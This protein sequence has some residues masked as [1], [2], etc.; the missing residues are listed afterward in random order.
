MLAWKAA[1]ADLD[2]DLPICDMPTWDSFIKGHRISAAPGERG[3]RWAADRRPRMSLEARPDFVLF[4]G[5]R[6]VIHRQW[7]PHPGT[8]MVWIESVLS[9]WE[10]GGQAG[11]WQV[12]RGNR[13]GARGLLRGTGGGF[14]E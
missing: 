12:G 14:A 1:Q 9:N 10:R 4:P 2:L 3:E 13:F 6:I 11:S 5:G 8:R 7:A